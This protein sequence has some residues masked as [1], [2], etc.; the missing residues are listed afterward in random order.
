MYAF[1][2]KTI[3]VFDRCSVD[4]RRKRIEKYEFT[5][6]NALVWTGPK[7][8]GDNLMDMNRRRVCWWITIYV[9]LTHVSKL[10]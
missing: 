4:D 7:M 6:E 5:N 3:S 9:N 1:S 10:D 8:D 2:M